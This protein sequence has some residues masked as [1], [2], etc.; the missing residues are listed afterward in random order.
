MNKCLYC[1]VFL[2]YLK[3]PQSTYLLFTCNEWM[4]LTLAYRC[5]DVD[6]K[7]KLYLLKL[8][9]KSCVQDKVSF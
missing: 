2:K 8:Y 9:T 6:R 1:I 5:K 7:K 4:D 3:Y